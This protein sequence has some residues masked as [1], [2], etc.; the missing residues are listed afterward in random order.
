MVYA[1]IAIENNTNY[2]KLT[3]I[4]SYANKALHSKSNEKQ[5]ETKLIKTICL[6]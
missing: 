3:Q 6:S 5:K 1:L 2:Q 4:I